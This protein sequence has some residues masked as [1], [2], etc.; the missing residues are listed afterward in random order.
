MADWAPGESPLYRNNQWTQ[1]DVDLIV[2]LRNNAEA[3]LDTADEIGR[4]RERLA[5]IEELCAKAS[6]HFYW[7]GY[8]EDG[9]EVECC[10]CQATEPGCEIRRQLAA[11]APVEGAEDADA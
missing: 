7:T 9:D 4:L 1:D 10:T 3:L 11:Y 6:N 5:A 2:A 8:T